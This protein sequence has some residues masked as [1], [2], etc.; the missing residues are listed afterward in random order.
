MTTFHQTWN[1]VPL[2]FHLAQSNLFDVPV[3]AIVN[4]E[5]SDFILSQRD[6]SISGQI[7]HRYGPEI[8]LELAKLTGG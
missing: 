6:S 1:L 5:Q 2:D 8:R 4:S 7:W 3:E